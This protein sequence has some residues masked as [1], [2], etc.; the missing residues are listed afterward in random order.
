[1]KYFCLGI[2][3][4]LAVDV[5]NV[6]ADSEGMP[7]LNSEF[8][9]AQI[10]WLLLIFFTLYLLISKIFL[11][12]IIYSIENRKTKIVN[13]INEAQKLKE[14]AESKLKEYNQIIEKLKNEAKKIV[15][16]SKKNL[17]KDIKNKKIEFNKEIEKELIN[18]ENEIKKLKKSSISNINKIAVEASSEIIKLIIGSEI[19]KSN[20]SAIVENV[21]KNKMDKYL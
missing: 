13:D 15:N 7:Q 4:V 6:F 20:V 17:D 10:F 5:T 8:W 18:T 19:N 11:P 16:E 1:M 9:P 3:I 21:S 2:Y 12:R 14:K